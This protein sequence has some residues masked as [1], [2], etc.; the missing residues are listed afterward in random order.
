MSHTCKS[1]ISHTWT[2]RIVLSHMWMSHVTIMNESRHACLWGMSHFYRSHVVTHVNESCHRAELLQNCDDFL[3]YD[4]SCHLYEWVTSH[5]SMSPVARMNESCHTYEW[6]ISHIWLSHITHMNE[7]CHTY[8]WVMSHIWLSHVTHM[9]KSCYTYEWV[10]SRSRAAE[11]REAEELQGLH[12]QVLKTEWVM[13]HMWMSYV[14]HVNESC[15]TYD[16]V[17]SHI[18]MSHITQSRSAR[19]AHSSLENWMGSHV[20]HMGWLWLVG[21][22]KS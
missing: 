2:S 22:L 9:N 8:D 4:E 14:T 21:S 5:K 18:W 15:H 6:V 10:M 13:P 7:S 16:W 12:T 11:K 19:T 20:T 1:V 3:S 17:M